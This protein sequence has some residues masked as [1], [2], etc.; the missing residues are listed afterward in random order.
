MRKCFTIAAVMT[1]LILAAVPVLADYQTGLGAYRVHDYKWAM[2]EFKAAKDRDSQYTLGVMYYKGEGV[3]ADHL[4]GIEWFRKAAAQG[5]AQAQFLLGTFYD[6]G[7]DV[8][9]DR[10]AAAKWYRK[11]AEK[12]HTQAM[13]NMGLMYVNGEGVEKDRNMAVLWLK[14]AAHDGHQDAGRLLKTMGEEVPAQ[15]LPKGGK[16]RKKAPSNGTPSALP[17]GHP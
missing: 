8:V 10:A 3:K 2:K 15:A 11:A 9:Q 1:G 17:P 16:A 7:K 5:H 13:F 6:A 4:E 14:K 12:G